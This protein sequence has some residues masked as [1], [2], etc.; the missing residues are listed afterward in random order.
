VEIGGKYATCIID[1]GDGCPCLL[2]EASH[3]ENWPKRLFYIWN[4][5]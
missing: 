1:L 2:V 3:I 4:S 5:L